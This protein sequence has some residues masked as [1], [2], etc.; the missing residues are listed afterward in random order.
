MTALA[1]ARDTTQVD[2]TVIPETQSLPVAA[3]TAIWSGS[4]VFTDANGR[5][6]PGAATSTLISAGVAQANVLNRTTDPS[7]GGAGAL[8]VTV[9]RGAWGFNMGAGADAI[10]IANRNQACYASDDNTVNLTDGAGTRPF[11]GTIYDVVGTQAIVMV[12]LPVGAAAS[13]GGGGGGTLQSGMLPTHAVRGV[14]TG[15]VAA[16]A[17]FTVANDGITLVAGDRV[18]LPFQT[19]GSQ[20]GIYVVGTVGAGTAPL[21]R[22]VD[23]DDTS[24]GEVVPTVIVGIAEGTYGAGKMFELITAAPITVGTTALAFQQTVALLPTAVGQVLR[25][26]TLGT[27]TVP[28]E[29]AYG[30][31]NLATTAAVTGVLSLA[32]ESPQSVRY[33]MTSNVAA[34][35]TFTVAQDGVTGVAGETVLLVNQTSASQNGPYVIGTVGGGTAPLTR[36]TWFPAAAVV[37]G[38]FSFFVNEGTQGANGLWVSKTAGNITIDTTAFTLDMRDGNWVQMVNVTSAATQANPAS[39]FVAA[40]QLKARLSGIFKVD[41]DIAFN[42]GTTGDV[43]TTTFLTDTAAAGLIA[44]ANKAAHGVVGLGTFGTNGVDAETMDGAG[45]LTYNGAAWTTAPITHKIDT[46][47]S[48]TGLLTAQASGHL[49]F[50]FHGIVHNANATTKT[51]FT[52]GNTVGFGVKFSATNTLTFGSIN[53]SVTE[54]P[55]Q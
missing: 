17:T 44:G 19:T 52:I 31:L 50:S 53:M 10:T 11:V 37:R 4:L 15:N 38:G 35:A 55:S 13:G 16:L 54:L 1:A 27:S 7:G 48:L 41:I 49:K 25:A 26:V 36:P 14:T 42:S 28:G 12:G 8:S 18:L 51:P 34:L 39:V 3:N 32:N 40:C 33:V 9:K 30:A 21:T 20:N 6:V 47:A 5:A 43:I 45:N 2:T 23:F 29:M 22:A 46:F 24:L